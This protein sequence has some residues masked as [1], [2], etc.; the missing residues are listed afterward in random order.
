MS[1]KRQLLITKLLKAQEELERLEKYNRE[2]VGK[3][4]LEMYDNNEIDSPKIKKAVA[5]IL[6]DTKDSDKS[7]SE[8]IQSSTDI[9][10]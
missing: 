10:T 5:K 2:Q 3:I 6:G 4:I 9:N 1:N 7:N 8:S